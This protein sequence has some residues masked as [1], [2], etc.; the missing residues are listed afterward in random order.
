MRDG[1]AMKILSPLLQSQ[2]PF[3]LPS[4]QMMKNAF[5]S[6]MAAH[7]FPLCL[8]QPVEINVFLSFRAFINKSPGLCT[9]ELWE[10]INHCHQDGALARLDSAR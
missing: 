10:N 2:R 5:N 4:S 1:A 9:F 6:T 7:S 8:H 3:P